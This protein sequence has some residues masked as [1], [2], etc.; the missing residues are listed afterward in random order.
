MSRGTCDECGQGV[1]W[2]RTL[3]GRQMMPVD[4]EPYPDDDATATLA[5]QPSTTGDYVRTI[6]TAEP[7]IDGVERRYMP[8]FATCPARAA[9]R[10]AALAATE[11]EDET[12]WWDR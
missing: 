2:A 4:P 8:H 6:T 11:Q 7:L 1:M 9:A 3:A 5:R 10:R 12:E